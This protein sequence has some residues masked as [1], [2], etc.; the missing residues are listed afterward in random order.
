VGITLPRLDRALELS[1]SAE[2]EPQL[3]AEAL[4]VRGRTHLGAGQLAA[5]R[6]DLEAARTAFHALGAVEREKRVLVDLCIVARDQ[7]DM[8]TAWELVQMAQGLPSAGDRWLD[9]YAVGN[10]GILE[11]GRHGAGAALAP[12]R[13]ALELFQETGD[14]AF[15]VGFLTNYAMAL[16]EAGGTSEA[17]HL[18]DE[19]LEKAS[20]VGDRSGQALARVN[21]GCC[22]L[23]VGR[24]AEAREHLEDTVRMGRQLGMR[25]LEGVS[26]G[27]LG[28]ALVAF[29]ALEAAR[30]RL[31]ESVAVLTRVSRWHALRFTTHLS[32]VHAA[33]GELTAAR[34]GFDSLEATPELREDPMLRE[35]TSLQRASLAL[36]EAMRAPP[37]GEEAMRALESARLRVERA[38]NAPAEAA[39]SDL[40]E[41]LRVLDRCVQTLGA[42]A[43]QA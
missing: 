32:A 36:A 22:L 26:L 35:L 27:E 15:E 38:R 37:G 24:A 34:E 7:G 17:V 8:G 30:A 39:S 9:A 31:S 12:L 33:L 10:L 25:L 4:A 40:R 28:R 23:D 6:K 16:C 43:S 18:L 13:T 19:A 2:V 20:R 5:A 1:A 42:G 3:R 41:A 21:L 11:L 29:G 14:V